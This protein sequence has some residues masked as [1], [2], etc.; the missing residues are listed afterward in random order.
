[1]NND[2]RTNSDLTVVGLLFFL[3]ISLGLQIRTNYQVKYLEKELVSTVNVVYYVSDKLDIAYGMID[4]LNEEQILMQ[5]NID[6]LI[7]VQRI[8]KEL[9]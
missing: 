6:S 5:Q 9:R 7:K 3:L 4:S 2:E 1:M 8:T